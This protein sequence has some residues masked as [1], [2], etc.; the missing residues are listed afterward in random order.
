MVLK[1]VSLPKVEWR[2]TPNA[3][4]A[5]RLWIDGVFQCHSISADFVADIQRGDKDVTDLFITSL[6]HLPAPY[7]N[8]AKYIV[9][10]VKAIKL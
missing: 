10:V 5:Y 6:G 3:A 7:D 1:L 9:S 2:Y 8:M 4:F